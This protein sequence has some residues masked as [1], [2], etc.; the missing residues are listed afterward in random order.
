[1]P[2]QPVIST[3]AYTADQW[4]GPILEEIISRETHSWKNQVYSL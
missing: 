4:T 3:R 1:M 2:Q